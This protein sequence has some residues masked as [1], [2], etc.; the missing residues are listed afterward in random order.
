MFADLLH[1][2]RLE[3]GMSVAELAQRAGTS[4]AAVAD[5][6]SGRKQP[7][8][9]TAARLLAVLGKT[10]VAEPLAETPMPSSPIPPQV[11]RTLERAR[12]T[13]Q[14]AIT[15]AMQ[16]LPAVLESDAELENLGLSWGEVK[17]VA[18]GIT[19]SGAPL[20]VDRLWSLR[21]D[22]VRSLN[23]ALA[24]RAEPLRAVGEYVVTEAKHL[25]SP[26]R[27]LDFLIR[28]TAA[29]AD[30]AR[31]RHLAAASLA[32]SGFPYLWVPFKSIE[33]YA[34]GVVAARLHGDGTR[35]LAALAAH[36]PDEGVSD[37]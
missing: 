24:G 25:P 12:S 29:G 5:Y 3:R 14:Q 9:D 22:V 8:V 17:T 20:Q 10:L 21:K 23:A 4:R 27:Q 35:M 32:A 11:V 31:V 16:E 7:R 36:I 2:A 28:A 30:P 26:T 33:D 37:G 19:I 18:D 34:K 6:E 15:T 13:P 1:E